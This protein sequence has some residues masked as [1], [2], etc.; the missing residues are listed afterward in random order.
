MSLHEDEIEIDERLVCGLV[1]RAV[2][3][4]AIRAIRPLGIS[5]S[6]NALF[7]LGD[8]LL[9]RLPPTARRLGHDRKGS[10]VGAVSGP[11]TAGGGS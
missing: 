11:C 4:F 3:E 2:P 6:S 7:R 1:G 9:V 5:G 8:D 10:P